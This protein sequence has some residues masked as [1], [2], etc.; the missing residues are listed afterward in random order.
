MN[1][2]LTSVKKLL[3][4]T[5]DYEFFDGDIIVH[6]NSVFSILNQ[7]GIGPENG[8][9]IIDKNAVWSDFLPDSSKLEMVKSYVF[10]KV[11]MLF[12]P[13]LNSSVSASIEKQLSE[14]E[15]RI[16]TEHEQSLIDS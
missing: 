6:I 9:S 11:K 2:I 4:L 10:L 12:D 1:S 15:W 8:F 3:G 13:P 7:L 5:E 16:E 14:L